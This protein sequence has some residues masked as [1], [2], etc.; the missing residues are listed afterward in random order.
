[1]QMEPLN[2]IINASDSQYD[3]KTSDFKSLQAAILCSYQEFG[4]QWFHLYNSAVC[5]ILSTLI[6]LPWWRSQ[7][8]ML[9]TRAF[10]SLL[11]KF[12]KLKTCHL[13]HVCYRLCPSQELIILIVPG[14]KC[15]LCNYVTHCSEPVAG[16]WISHRA[17]AD[18][19]LTFIATAS[20]YSNLVLFAKC[21]GCVFVSFLA[22]Q[23]YP[24][25]IIGVLN[26]ST[27]SFNNLNDSHKT[28]SKNNLVT[29]WN[30]ITCNIQSIFQKNV[31]MMTNT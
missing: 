26:S 22:V 12:K 16:S 8:H 14:N 27:Q 7:K 23:M 6:M 11:H 30:L 29:T 4:A 1:M 18:A 13:S 9:Y 15:K 17:K 3:H 20:I 2:V 28:T 25:I 24:T 31:H 19:H 5:C 10:V 21:V